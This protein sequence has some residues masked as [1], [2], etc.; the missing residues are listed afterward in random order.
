MRLIELQ[1]TEWYKT[2]P[3]IIKDLIDQFPYAAS[4]RIR[5][6][7]QLAYIY[8]W[9]EDGTISVVITKEDNPNIINALPDEAYRVFGYEP[10][11]L[12]FIQENPDLDLDR[13]LQG[14]IT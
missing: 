6:T 14:E 9:N 13:F 10:N 3:Q 4:V 2:R 8:S 11:D 7:S 1:Q 5:K 12:V